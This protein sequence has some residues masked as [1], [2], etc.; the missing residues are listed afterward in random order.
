MVAG[1]LSGGPRPVS[2]WPVHACV[3][4]KPAAKPTFGVTRLS[5]LVVRAPFDARQLAV[6]RDDATMADDPYNRFPA[7]P[8]QLLKGPAM[9]VL[10]SSGKF[11]AV[12]GSTS[13]ASVSHVAE[14]TVTALQLDC[15]EGD[16]GEPRREAQVGVSLL[17]LDRDRAIVG[18]GEGFGTGDARKGNYGE[19]FSIAFTS[20]LL[21][22][23]EDL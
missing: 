11:A 22:A 10:A 1:C 2:S 5:Q 6:L 16:G 21:A 20:S 18:M 12:V 19:A 17:V 13:A 4:A 7:A 9:D 23:L 3:V 14:I 15:K 8:S